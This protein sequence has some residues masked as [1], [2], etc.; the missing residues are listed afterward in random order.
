VFGEMPDYDAGDPLPRIVALLSWFDEQPAWLA[1]LVASMGRA[2]VDHVVAVDGA[3]GAYPDGTGNSGSEQAQVVAATALGAGMGCTIHIPSEAWAGNEIEKRTFLFAL[4]HLVAV[5]DRDWLWVL[6]G[7]EV[8]TESAGLKE[9]LEGTDKQVATVNLWEGVC[10]GE[11]ENTSMTL[12]MLFRAQRT[13]ISVQGHHAHYRS[14]DGQVLWNACQPTNE[15]PV[16]PLERMVHVRH[17]PGDRQAYRNR[18]RLGYYDRTK[19][20]N[21][22][23]LG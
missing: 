8:I 10:S 18:K 15:T 13:G 4:A 9:A 6:D 14:G 19:D 7:D 12:R 2:G 11:H 22:E 5:P 17:R 16:L 1:E 3:Y 23:Q 21:L 20:M